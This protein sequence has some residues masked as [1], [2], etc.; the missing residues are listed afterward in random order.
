VHSLGFWHL[1]TGGWL[2]YL[3]WAT[4]LDFVLKYT[5]PI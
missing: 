2:L 3:M 5:L 4:V 1:G